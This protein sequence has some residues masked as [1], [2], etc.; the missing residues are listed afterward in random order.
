MTN[1]QQIM[2]QAQQMQSRMEELQGELANVEVTGES[3]G[4]MVKATLTCRGQMTNLEL[5]PSVISADDKE[6]MEDLIKAAVNDARTKADQ[7]MSEETQ[8]MMQELGLPANTQ[9]PF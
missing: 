3:G 6:M 9:L 5:D 4:G 1:I 7:K 8:K 2:Q